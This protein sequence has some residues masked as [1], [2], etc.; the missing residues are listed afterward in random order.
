[1]ENKRRLLVLCVVAVTMTGCAEMPRQQRNTA[2]GATAGA[3]AGSIL[4]DGDPLATL[5]GAAIGGVIGYKTTPT[6]HH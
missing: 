6:R 3:V 1:M 5:G 2:I 4:T